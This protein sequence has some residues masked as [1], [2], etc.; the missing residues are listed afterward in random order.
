L[1]IPTAGRALDIF[2][3]WRQPEIPLQIVT[4]SWVDYSHVSLVN[5]RRGQ[6]LVRIQCLAIDGVDSSDGATDAGGGW[7]IEMVPLAEDVAGTLTPVPGEGLWLQ[8]S[9][10]LLTRA[11]RLIDAVERVVRWRDGSPAELSP[12]QWRDDPLVV[13]SLRTEFVPETVANQG[14]AVR[15]VQGRSFTCD[16][17]VMSASDT[18]AVEL[19]QGRLEQVSTHEVSV[20]VNADIP[21]L[22]IAYAAERNQSASRLDP[23]SR[24]F[25]PPPPQNEVETME[26]VAFGFDASPLLGSH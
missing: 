9:Q 22:G 8:V 4:G 15:V 6:D 14:S 25:D 5:G 23:P 7:V 16:Q 17:Y 19:P 12:D 1:L 20:A 13:V 10:R 18:V 2:T 24:R 11:G 21:L 3:L 26:L